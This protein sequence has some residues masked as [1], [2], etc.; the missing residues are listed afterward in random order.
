[1]DSKKI[2]TQTI[3]SLFVL[4]AITAV[5]G[6]PSG[7]GGSGSDFNNRGK[8]IQGPDDVRFFALKDNKSEERKYIGGVIGNC[9]GFSYD[10][11]VPKVWRKSGEDS[12]TP[13]D[14][15]KCPFCAVQ[16]SRSAESKS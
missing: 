8:G 7:A 14:K 9:E 12:A 1:M 5:N 4:I 10:G 16:N 13:A 6:R 11:L 15:I 3:V 2:I